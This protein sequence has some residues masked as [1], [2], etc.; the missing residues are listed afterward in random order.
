MILTLLAEDK[1]LWGGDAIGLKCYFATGTEPAG[2]CFAVVVFW[3]FGGLKEV[4]SRRPEGLVLFCHN[5]PP[6]NDY[7]IVTYT[8]INPQD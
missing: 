3:H 8:M 6:Y 2:F 4:A 7:I 5:I 1:G